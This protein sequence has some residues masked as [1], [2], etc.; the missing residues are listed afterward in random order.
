[1]LSQSPPFSQRP[2]S[3]E[4]LNQFS[5]NDRKPVEGWLN[6]LSVIDAELFRTKMLVHIKHYAQLLSPEQPVALYVERELRKY[7]GKSQYAFHEKPTTLATTKRRVL[8]S[9]GSAAKIK[10][11]QQTRTV[12]PEIGSE[13][14]IANL[15]TQLQRDNRGR[16][17]LNAGPDVIR[18]RGQTIKVAFVVCDFIG[19]GTR[20][21]SFLD[22]FWRMATVKS[23]RSLQLLKFHVLAYSGTPEG[24][25]AVRTHPC[26]PEVNWIAPCPTIDTEYAETEANVLRE[27]FINHDPVDKD[28]VE[29]L[30]YCGQG[31]MLVFAHGCPNNAPRVLYKKGRGRKKWKP[32]LRE[33]GNTLENLRDH[34]NL[35]R[36][37]TRFGK[38]APD[39]IAKRLRSAALSSE[40]VDRLLVLTA[41]KAGYRFNEDIAHVTGIDL[42]DIDSAINVLQQ[43]G[44][45]SSRN[46]LTSEGH[47]N[48]TLAGPLKLK[49]EKNTT[50]D[51]FGERVYYPKS[52]RPPVTS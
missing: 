10:V 28:P 52:L 37:L 5:S 31:A 38:F 22:A 2:E 35:K 13:G 42:P 46:R 12:L 14:I 20:V 8:R 26:K 48:L 40:G 51:F 43:L 1:M 39:A 49:K 32:L 3:Q 7:L 9:Y 23:W 17:I 19:T 24:I 34:D 21:N 44:W 11:V 29:S 27:I 47:R 4:W 18:Q 6:K 50:S 15:L 16:F 41:L 45:I 33:R 25:A 30:G 36:R